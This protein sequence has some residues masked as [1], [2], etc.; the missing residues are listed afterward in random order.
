M[1]Q[2]KQS[3]AMTFQGVPATD[4]ATGELLPVETVQ[5]LVAYAEKY[6]L[7]PYRGHV[8]VMYSKPYIT[9]DGY[10]FA[11][12]RSGKPY[13]LRSRPMTSLEVIEYKIEPTDHGWISE[14]EFTDTGAKFTGT[15]IVT[16]EEMTAKSDRDPTKF[17]APVVAKHPWQLAQKRA[18][19]QALRRGFPIGE[20]KENEEV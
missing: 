15:G 2:G 9:L 12:N 6:A 13:S 8:V 11:A 3:T 10:L 5:A 14:L 17:K 7:D 18:E 20:T 19:W 1:S 4:L 16:Y